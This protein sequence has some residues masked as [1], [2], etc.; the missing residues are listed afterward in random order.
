MKYFILCFVTMIA[1]SANPIYASTITSTFNDDAEGWTLNGGILTHLA[2][3]GNPGGHLTMEDN[4]SG[5]MNT[6]APET[7]LGDL[8]AFDG[9]LL[10]LD[11]I[12]LAK[13]S[14]YDLPRFGT[15]TITSPSVSAS[16]DLVSESPAGF[17]AGF[18]TT[19]TASL[20]AASWGKTQLAWDSILSNV[21]QISIVTD[22]FNRLEDTIGFDNFKI[23]DETIVNP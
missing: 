6:V 12:L 1:I 16:L 4:I 9:G 7:F 5:H 23:V 13:N 15:I 18:W 2:A 14:N 8:S 22:P 3:G 20:D 21:T 10:S 11:F 19:Y 17:W